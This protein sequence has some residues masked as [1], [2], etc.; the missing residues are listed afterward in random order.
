MAAG[1]G[2]VT[3]NVGSDNGV[4][5]SGSSKSESCSRCPWTGPWNGSCDWMACHN[6][7]FRLRQWQ[8]RAL[9]DELQ[10]HCGP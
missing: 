5:V 1:T 9:R 10:C 2:G 7:Q 8:F 6:G 3:G 4:E